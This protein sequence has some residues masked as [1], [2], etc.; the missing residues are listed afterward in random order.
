MLIPTPRLKTVF[1]SR[2]NALWLVLAVVAAVYEL[3]P[4]PDGEASK[5]SQSASSPWDKATPSP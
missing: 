5:P 4:A 1:A 3:V 2:W